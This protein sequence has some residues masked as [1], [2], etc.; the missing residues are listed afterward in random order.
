[1][2]LINSSSEGG[3]GGILRLPMTQLFNSQHFVSMIS[4]KNA[5]F[6]TV[7]GNE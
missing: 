1:V 3:I 5:E 6:G 2:D 7:T 4:V